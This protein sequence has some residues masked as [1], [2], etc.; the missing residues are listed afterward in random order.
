MPFG[1]FFALTRLFILPTFT[2][3]YRYICNCTT[4]GKITDLWISAKIANDNDLLD[5]I[6]PKLGSPFRISGIHDGS[7]GEVK[8][9]AKAKKKYK[10]LV[11]EHLTKF[12]EEN[13][14]YEFEVDV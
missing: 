9:D 2:R 13:G 11:K 8:I 3:C 1:M 4:T 5:L 14:A 7:T 10:P 6:I 12:F